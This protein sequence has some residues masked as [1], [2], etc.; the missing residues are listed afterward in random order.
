[1]SKLICL[2]GVVAP[3]TAD[4]L[5]GLAA[6]SRIVRRATPG[7]APTLLSALIDLEHQLETAS[8]ELCAEQLLSEF[9]KEIA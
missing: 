2:P 3:G 4:F 5:E 7:I 1:M 9:A 6:Q 8:A